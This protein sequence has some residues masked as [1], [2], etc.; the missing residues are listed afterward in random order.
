MYK[1]LLLL[2]VLVCPISMGTMM[3]FMMRSNKKKDKE[4]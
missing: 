4:E 1:V 2:A 3:F